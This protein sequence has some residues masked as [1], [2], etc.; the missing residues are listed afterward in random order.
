MGY[1]HIN[2]IKVRYFKVL[3]PF[4]LKASILRCNYWLNSFPG[5][6]V[7]FFLYVYAPGR[8]RTATARLSSEHSNL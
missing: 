2:K 5:L 8:N 7:V 6:A 4:E 3:K 1:V